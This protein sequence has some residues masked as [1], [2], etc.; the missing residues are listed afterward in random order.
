MSS[1]NY[2]D[3]SDVLDEL[4]GLITASLAFR[5]TDELES[6]LDALQLG[7]ALP[8]NALRSANGAGLVHIDPR[9]SKEDAVAALLSVA[10]W[11]DQNWEEFS[12]RLKSDEDEDEGEDED[13]DGEIQEADEELLN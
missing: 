11:V 10:E 7:Q 9:A 5:S 13:E 8:I 6:L 4:V 2:R 3:R 1:G 12:S